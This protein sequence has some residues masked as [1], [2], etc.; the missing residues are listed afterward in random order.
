M[1]VLFYPTSCTVTIH[2]YI[3]INIYYTMLL[4]NW[5]YICR[6][7]ESPPVY[8]ASMLPS[9]YSKK[10]FTTSESLHFFTAR[11]LY[12]LTCFTS[13][14]VETKLQLLCILWTRPSCL[15]RELSLSATARMSSFPW[16][17]PV[18]SHHLWVAYAWV[19]FYTC[20]CVHNKPGVLG[21]GKPHG[22]P[23][24]LLFFP[25]IP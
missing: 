3:H 8:R 7:C 9:A 25:S 2:I 13:F 18:L 12:R 5:F 17:L 22:K 6:E 24:S 1:H 20:P 14:C 10:A 11:C 23:P 19:E 15:F 21:G 4:P 16:P